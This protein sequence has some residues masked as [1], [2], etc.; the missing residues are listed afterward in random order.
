MKSRTTHSFWQAY[1]TLPPTV[2]RA[3]VR[4]Y[5]LWR[6]NPDHPG[7][8]FK[9]IS[10][11]HAVFSARIGLHWRALGYKERDTDGEVIIWFWIGSHGDYDK[12]VSSL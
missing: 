1:D 9:R 7:V 8:R 6:A 10:G 2:R 5:T 12:L 3:A 4:A 11:G